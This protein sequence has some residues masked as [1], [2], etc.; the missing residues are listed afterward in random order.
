MEIHVEKV[1]YVHPKT[2][3]ER[4]MSQLWKEILQIDRVGLRDDFFQIGGDSLSV[5][6]LHQQVKQHVD[7]EISIANLYRYR[8]IEAFLDY[9]SQK[10]NTSA[11]H[12]A[13]NAGRKELLLQGNEKRAQR[14]SKRKGINRDE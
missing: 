8:T 6:M 10:Q 12:T 5:I 2:G 9:L 14:L 3:L 1:R 4:Q 7:A 13:S 11:R